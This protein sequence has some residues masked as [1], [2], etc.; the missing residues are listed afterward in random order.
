MS[1]R[2]NTARS[3]TNRTNFRM[4]DFADFAIKIAP[5]LSTRDE[6]LALL[7][8]V[9]GEQV[10]FSSEGDPLLDLVDRRLADD[11]EHVNIFREVRSTTL[12]SE[13]EKTA[14]VTRFRGSA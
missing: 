4:A 11:S 7:D 3:A 2:P 6:I 10:A 8:R 12:A 13:L 14:A 5:V 9:S 1:G